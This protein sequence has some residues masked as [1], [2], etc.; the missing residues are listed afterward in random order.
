MHILC[1]PVLLVVTY[2]PY[3]PIEIPLNLVLKKIGPRTM[4][5]CLCIMWGAVSTSQC[6]VQNYAGLLAR[7]FFLGLCEGG[8]FPGLYFICPTS[9]KDANCRLELK[10]IYGA[11]SVSGAFSGHLAPGIKCL[12]R[13]SNLGGGSSSWKVS[14]PLS[15]ASSRFGC[16]PTLPSVARSRQVCIY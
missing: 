12:D 6:L 16:Y 5:P 2:I 4:L 11:A 1:T 14:P 9:I 13:K 7:R 15:S 3:I 10:C 8:L